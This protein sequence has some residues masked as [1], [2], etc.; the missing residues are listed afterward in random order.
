MQ[1][2]P[3][4]TGTRPAEPGLT[5]GYMGGRSR[6]RTWVGLAD[7]FTESRRPA[8][9]HDLYLQRD[10]P[11]AP[12]LPPLFR[13]GCEEPVAPDLVRGLLLHPS[14]TSPRWRA[15]P[16]T[17]HPRALV[18]R[19]CMARWRHSGRRPAA[20]VTPRVSRYRICRP[21]AWCPMDPSGGHPSRALTG[22]P[23]GPGHLRLSV[24]QGCPN[25][26]QHTRPPGHG[27]AGT[28]RSGARPG[29]S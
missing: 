6:V 22:K 11:G 18:S 2:A 27:H 17:P 16:V 28:A 25:S 21:P 23:M 26:T 10:R 14:P 3:P 12:P 13:R 19:A 24:R 8:R 29:R 4:A 5:C 9:E 15:C 1:T 7:G 20:R